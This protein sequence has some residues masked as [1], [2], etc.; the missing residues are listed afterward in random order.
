MPIRLAL[1]ARFA[2]IKMVE[3]GK[4]KPIIYQPFY[5]VLVI[6]CLSYSFCLVLESEP[7]VP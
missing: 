3:N 4:L 6:H 2:G 5:Q 1:I 7:T